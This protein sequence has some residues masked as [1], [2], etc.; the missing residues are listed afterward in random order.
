ME[1]TDLK[2]LKNLMKGDTRTKF[3]FEEDHDE[4]DNEQATY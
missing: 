2:E 1:V 3:E 4:E